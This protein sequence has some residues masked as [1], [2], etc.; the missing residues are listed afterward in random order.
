MSRSTVTNL[1]LCPAR[2]ALSRLLSRL[3]SWR[4]ALLSCDLAPAPTEQSVPHTLHLGP[5]VS[6]PEH[7]VQR[8]ARL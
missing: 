3:S 1:L 8:P 6:L 4:L 2:P 7:S 5:G